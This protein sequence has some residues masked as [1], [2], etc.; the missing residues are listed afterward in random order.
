MRRQSR[1]LP[2]VRQAGCRKRLA[3]LFSKLSLAAIAAPFPLPT[4]GF[5]RLRWEYPFSVLSQ[6]ATTARQSTPPV[7][8]KQTPTGFGLTGRCSGLATLAA[9]LHFVRPHERPVTI[10]VRRVVNVVKV[11]GSLHRPAKLGGLQVAPPRVLLWLSSSVAPCG[12]QDPFP[13]FTAEPK[14]LTEG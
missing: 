6:G 4:L 3:L 10:N 12:S 13:F 2:R 9:E 5:D 14:V 8:L 1:G 7:A 11:S